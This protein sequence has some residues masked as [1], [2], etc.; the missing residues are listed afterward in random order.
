MNSPNDIA[1]KKP[2]PSTPPHML[3]P[4]PNQSPTPSVEVKSRKSSVVATLG[5]HGNLVEA[6]STKFT[7]DGVVPGPES[8]TVGDAAV[9]KVSR[10]SVILSYP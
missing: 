4:Q 10:A 2:P 8:R 7:M 6:M 5:D 9:R 3:L 1:I